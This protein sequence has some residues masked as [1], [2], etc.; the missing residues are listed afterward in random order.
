MEEWSSAN[1][2]AQKRLQSAGGAGSSSV[3]A[4]GGRSV[5][6]ETK[7]AKDLWQEDVFDNVPVGIRE[8]MKQEKRIREKHEREHA[9]AP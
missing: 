3:D 6:T 9:A 8:F 5:A 7:I 1:K 2:K 4:D